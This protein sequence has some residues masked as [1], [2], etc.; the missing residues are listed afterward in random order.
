MMNAWR[1]HNITFISQEIHLTDPFK[2]MTGCRVGD[3][4]AL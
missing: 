1:K 3:T 2:Y 4:F